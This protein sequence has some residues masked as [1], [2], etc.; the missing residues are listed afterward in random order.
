MRHLTFPSTANCRC[1]HISSA[2]LARPSSFTRLWFS[3]WRNMLFTVKLLLMRTRLVLAFIS[4]LVLCQCNAIVFPL[5]GACWG[6]FA[7]LLDTETLESRDAQNACIITK[8]GTVLNCDLFSCVVD[9]S[10]ETPTWSRLLFKSLQQLRRKRSGKV[11]EGH[12]LPCIRQLRPQYVRQ[13]N[14]SCPAETTR[15]AFLNLPKCSLFRVWIQHGDCLIEMRSFTKICLHCWLSCRLFQRIRGIAS[16]ILSSS[17]F[18][19]T[20]FDNPA[21]NCML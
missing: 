6:G 8:V 17:W 7:C 20:T 13:S 9:C 18:S 3:Y 2:L 4:V 10:C 16:H 11:F 5:S 1:S 21:C 15:H 14:L 12:Q 19:C